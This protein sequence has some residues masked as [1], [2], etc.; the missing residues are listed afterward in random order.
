MTSI[1]LYRPSMF[2]QI[3]T[4]LTYTLDLILIRTLEKGKLLDLQE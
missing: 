2:C 1:K 3:L 4:L